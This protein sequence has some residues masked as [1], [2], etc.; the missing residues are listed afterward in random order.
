MA[1]ATTG[2][3]IVA[4]AD[5]PVTVIEPRHRGPRQRALEVWRYRRVILYF[6]KRFVQKRY[7]RTW[8]GWVWLPLRPSVDVAVRVLVYGS[9]LRAPSEGKPYVIFFL[10][11]YSTWHLFG[12]T[13]MFATRS[14][15][16]NKRVLRRVY[17][18]RLTALLAASFPGVVEYLLYLAITFIAAFYYLATRGTFYLQFGV[19]VLEALAGLLLLVAF[20]IGIGL[21]TSIWGIRM[22]D[23]RFTLRYVLGFWIFLTPVI[24]PLTT[25]PSSYRW[26][27]ELNPLTAPILLVRHGLLGIETVPLAAL[28]ASVGLTL[29]LWAGGLWYYGRMEAAAVDTL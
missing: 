22:R 21:F 19:G 20:A 10:V 4:T 11:G 17:V 13:A 16:L 25:I 5:L 27:A 2:S 8:L 26:A 14:L 24:Y 9:L 3:P 15:E 6:G 7:A 28:G 12:H 29:L 23:V 18:P 1:V